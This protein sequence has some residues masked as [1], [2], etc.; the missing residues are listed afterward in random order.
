MVLEVAILNVIPSMQ[1]SF[2]EAYRQA[3][4][5]IAASEGY[6]SHELRRCVETP[7]RYLLLVEWQSIEDHIVGFRGSPRYAEWKKLLH[8]FY[9]PFPVVEHYARLGESRELP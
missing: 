7:N 8:K 1:K 4:P 9:D 5:L 2:E 6:I 3:C